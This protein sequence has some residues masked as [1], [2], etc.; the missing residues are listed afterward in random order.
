MFYIGF[1]LFKNERF[2]HSLLL[3]SNVSKLLK[4]LT[5]N[6]RMSEWLVFLSESLIC[7]FLGKKLAICS[8][9]R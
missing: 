1:F 5:K 9:N 3:V 7:S 6:E 2:A 8:E 4:S